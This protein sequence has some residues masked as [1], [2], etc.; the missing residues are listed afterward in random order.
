M[1]KNILF[2]VGSL[3]EGSF[4]YQMAKEVEGLLEGKAVVTY[5]DYKDV[6]VFNQ[7]LETPVLA[8]VAKVREEIQK[9]DAIWIFSPVYNSAIPGPVKNL[10]DWA[11]RVLDLTNPGGPSALQDKVVTVSSVA[12]SWQEKVFPA[13]IDL[14]TFVRTKVVGEFTAAK[15][16]PE[17]WG[18]G[19]LVLADE[20]LAAL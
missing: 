20:L 11:S 15:V 12:S 3:R 5:L 1:S 9:A 7:D 19:K 13:Y 2:L 16:N 14:L 6:P 18:N 8:S 17:A 10:L 4:N